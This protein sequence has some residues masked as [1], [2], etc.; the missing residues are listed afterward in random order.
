[1]NQGTQGYSYVSADDLE[2]ES[3]GESEDLGASGL[4]LVDESSDVSLGE[5]DDE[6]D[7]E[8]FDEELPAGC[9]RA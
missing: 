8:L 4:V 3:L 2:E 1:M 6:S 7:D 5:S 9:L